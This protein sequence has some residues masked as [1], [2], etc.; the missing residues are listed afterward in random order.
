MKIGV[1]SLEKV[2]YRG[3]AREVNCRTK[4]GEITILQNHE[5]I[6]SLLDR[7]TMKI[8]DTEA[9]EHYIP[10]RSGFL[11]FKNNEGRFLIEEER[12]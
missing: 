9:Q 8:V 6:I 2:L 11:E 7:G 12:A 3:D 1:Y 4:I 5:P 10:V